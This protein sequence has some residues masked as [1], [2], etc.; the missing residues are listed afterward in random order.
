MPKPST[1]FQSDTGFT[2]IELVIVIV[3]LGVLSAFALPRFADLSSSAKQAKIEAAYGA[4]QSA[5]SIV[6]MACKTDSTCNTSEAPTGGG[7][8]NSIELEGENIILAFGYPRRTEAGIARAS[9]IQD[10]SDGGDYLITQSTVSGIDRLRIRPNGDTAANNCEVLYR[11]A[12][13]AGQLPETTLITA[14]C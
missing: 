2:L 11:E 7:T 13:S 14:D 10:V 6:G 1:N 3:I 12:G 5:K 9:G 8:G 4:I